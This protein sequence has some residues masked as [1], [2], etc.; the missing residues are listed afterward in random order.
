[1]MRCKI[2]DATKMFFIKL[3]VLSVFFP[4]FEIIRNY[5]I[6]SNRKHRLESR[7]LER[8]E[9]LKILSKFS[10]SGMKILTH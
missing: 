8:V 3:V 1:M 6:D 10:I 2:D 4:I 7:R 5:C 9:N